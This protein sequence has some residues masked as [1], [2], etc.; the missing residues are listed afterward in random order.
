MRAPNRK[1]SRSVAF[2]PSQLAPI[3][4]CE[5]RLPVLPLVRGGV[6]LLDDA[7]VCLWRPTDTVQHA[8]GSLALQI[9]HPIA[10]TAV[11]E[12]HRAGVIQPRLVPAFT[13]NVVH[14]EALPRPA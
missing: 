11:E 5:L 9:H 7:A 12:Q 3:E 13:L 1:R 2:A 10:Q 14:I 8:V 6:P 4:S